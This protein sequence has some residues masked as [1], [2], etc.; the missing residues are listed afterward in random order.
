M[1]ERRYL[2]V[3]ICPNE[4]RLEAMASKL[5]HMEDI[6]VSM[7]ARYEAV[8]SLAD[9]VSVGAGRHAG[10]TSAPTLLPRNDGDVAV[11]RVPGWGA[12]LAGGP[13]LER[14]AVD[15]TRDGPA[16]VR[17]VLRE[18]GL[19][20]KAAREA[21]ARAREGEIF[22]F[23]RVSCEETAHE[24]ER[25]FAEL[26]M[27]G[28]F[29][30]TVHSS[31]EAPHRAERPRRRSVHTPSSE[32]PDGPV[33]HRMERDVETV[34]AETPLHEAIEKLR[35]LNAAFLPVVSK[36]KMVGILTGS[37]IPVRRCGLTSNGQPL[38]VRAVMTRH[39]AFCLGHQRAAEVIGLMERLQVSRLPVLDPDKH[40]LGMISSA[41]LLQADEREPLSD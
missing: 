3:A 21:E 41:T 30:G 20:G 14:L 35:S 38:P 9:R 12:V 37:E 23:A 25:R 29:E 31:T 15:R 36:G 28:F 26:G 24:A 40:L 8:K 5:E 13:L 1:V 10:A 34:P 32:F 33:R 11:I 39:F 6:E 17:K 16:S 18:L 27:V 4:L 22:V 7:L 2:V 19:G